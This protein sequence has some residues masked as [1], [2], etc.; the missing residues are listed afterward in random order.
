M[1]LF[2]VGIVALVVGF[3]L[4]AKLIAK[5]SLPGIKEMQKDQAIDRSNYLFTLRRELANKLIWQD[6]QRY[7]KLF[8]ELSS[9][10]KS[11]GSWRLEEINKRLAELS[12]KYPFYDDFDIIESKEYVLYS[13]DWL[14]YEELE[15][16]Y[17]DIA[18]FVAL[19]FVDWGADSE[20]IK[21]GIFALGAAAT[22]G[23]SRLWN[24]SGRISYG[25]LLEALETGAKYALAV[26]AAAATVGIVIGVVTL[27]GVGFKISYIITSAANG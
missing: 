6:P 8:Q 20:V 21:L 1:E 4:G 14:N 26:G 13:G 5:G 15:A 12:E 24:I 9:E 23:L 19:S 3:F 7:L 11:F 10:F 17:R 2:L 22:V 27:T 25:V 16:R 18:T